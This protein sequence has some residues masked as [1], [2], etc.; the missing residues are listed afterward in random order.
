MRSNLGSA[1][2]LSVL[3]VCTSLMACSEVEPDAKPDGVDLSDK[4]IF[5]A[6]GSGRAGRYIIE[7]LDARGLNFT[8]MTRDKQAAIERLG[9]AFS[10]IGWVEGDV[11]N[12]EQMNTLISGMDMV[13]CVIG[14]RETEGPNGPEFVDYKGVAN[15][16][17]AAVAAEV[18]H[19]VLLTAIGVTDE[20]HPLNKLLGNALIWRFKGET[21]LR[22]S[23]LTYTIVRP[24][25]LVDDPSGEK[26]VFLDQGDNWKDIFR[27][28]ITRGDLADVLIASLETTHSH[29]KTFE[30]VNRTDIDPDLWRD[31]FPSL[32]TDSELNSGTQADTP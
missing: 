18:E 24:A 9:T 6:G 13:I 15:L 21:H 23:G 1:L 31:S 10:E 29:N 2:A 14:S 22:E 17:D 20:N 30:I 7:R 5:V 12:A 8:P 4:A 28:T 32:V 19:F 11:R 26:G 27:G 3:I 16:V 25:G